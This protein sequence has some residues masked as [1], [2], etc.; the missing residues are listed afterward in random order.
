MRKYGGDL[1][2][3]EIKSLWDAQ[4]GKCAYT[5][6]PMVLP[7]SVGGWKAGATPFAASLDRKDSAKGYTPDNVEFVCRFVN[8]GKNK[9]TAAQTRDFIAQL[10][11]F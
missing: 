10:R 4:Q 7:D 5:G 6:L 2:L 9:F 11:K 3:A 1:T 8:L